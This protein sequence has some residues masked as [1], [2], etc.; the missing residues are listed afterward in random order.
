MLEMKE[1]STYAALRKQS[2]DLQRSF[3]RLIPIQTS[4]QI[5]IHESKQ[6]S[7]QVEQ[8]DADEE[9]IDTL[10]GNGK[11]STIIRKRFSRRMHTILPREFLDG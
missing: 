6:S 4:E 2:E 1:Y 10:S 9:N 11:N 3:E 7:E 8:N 5:Q